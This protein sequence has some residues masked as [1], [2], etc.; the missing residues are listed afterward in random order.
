MTDFYINCLL[1]QF[2]SCHLLL[3]LAAPQS[4]IPGYVSL[5]ENV[6]VKICE[7]D[8]IRPQLMTCIMVIAMVTVISLS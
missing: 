1:Q 4:I 7:P 5:E 6:L 8:E 2:R 3:T